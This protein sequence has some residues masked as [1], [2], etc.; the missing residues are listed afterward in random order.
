MDSLF[1]NNQDNRE[2]EPVDKFDPP[3]FEIVLGIWG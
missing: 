1:P 3:F 2:E